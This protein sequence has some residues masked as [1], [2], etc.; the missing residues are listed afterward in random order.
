MDA[1]LPEIEKSLRP[2][3]AQFGQRNDNSAERTIFDILD[4]DR[5]SERRQR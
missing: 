3:L 5:F 4:S 2:H 1:S